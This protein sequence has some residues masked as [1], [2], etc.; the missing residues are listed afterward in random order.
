MLRRNRWKTI[1]IIVLCAALVLE[2]GVLIAR[3]GGTKKVPETQFVLTIS[4]DGLGDKLG[5]KLSRTLTDT[6]TSLI[7]GKIP[8]GG[9]PAIAKTFLYQDFL[10]NA[11]MSVSFPLLVRVLKD[12]EMLD[13]SEAARLHPLPFQMAEVLSGKGYT[14]CDK[15]G[16]RK[17]ICEVLKTANDNWAFF[18]EKISW[19]D[20]DGTDMNTTVW[21]SIHWNITDETSFFTAMNDM[22]EGLR[23]VLEICLQNKEVVANVNALEVLLGTDAIPLNIDAATLFNSTGKS[24][25]ETCLIPLFNMLGLDEGEYVSDSDFCGY[26]ELS[27]IWKA[28]FD[29]IMKVLEKTE[30]D[31]VNMLTSMLVN[32]ADAMD[33]GTIVENMKT[34]KLDADFNV[35]ASLAMGYKDGLLSNLGELLVEVIESLGIKF[36]GNF[37][38]LLDSLPGLIPSVGAMDLPDMDVNKLVSCASEKTLANGNKVYV[39]DAAAV[40]DYLVDYAVNEQI[41]QILFEKT[42]FLTPDEEA[43]LVSSLGNSKEGIK[44][45]IKTVIPIVLNKLSAAA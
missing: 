39:A 35:L 21:N 29:N 4:M 37:N 25:Y 34:L 44:Q 12:I 6:V 45:L 7:D 5:A 8:E 43:K 19:K 32:F 33:K 27:D 11:V 2:S 30:K 38:E 3:K 23:G 16:S 42:D 31:P 28:I 22:S 15:D 1:V 26:T 9:I 13:F 20:D 10:I 36:S 41:F 14:C 18:D 40:V 17:D 24:G